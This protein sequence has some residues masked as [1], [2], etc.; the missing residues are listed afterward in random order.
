MSLILPKRNIVNIGFTSSTDTN[1]SSIKEYTWGV[2]G[3]SSSIPVPL[4]FYNIATGFSFDGTFPTPVGTMGVGLFTTGVK[5]TRVTEGSST[6]DWT[7]SSTDTGPISAFRAQLT[8]SSYTRNNPLTTITDTYTISTMSGTASL[9]FGLIGSNTS[10]L[11]TY[12]P[13]EGDY[14]EG[15]TPIGALAFGGVPSIT[16]GTLVVPPGAYRATQRTAGGGSNT[17]VI[18]GPTTLSCGTSENSAIQ[19]A[20]LV[21][22]TG[23]GYWTGNSS[24]VSNQ[25][26]TN[27]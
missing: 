9:S 20:A 8:T 7:I 18:M 24:S 27:Q 15:D 22:G 13:R 17:V 10:D 4:D 25:T 21:T 1:F 23:S 3:F 16:C 2:A 26:I 14:T 5:T 6:L 19:Y 11:T 12:N